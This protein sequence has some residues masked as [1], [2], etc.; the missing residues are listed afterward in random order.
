MTKSYFTTIVFLG[1]LLLSTLPGNAQDLSKSITKHLEI[2]KINASSYVHISTI[3]LDSGNTYPCNGFIYIDDKEAF[4]FDSPANE[5]AVQELIKLLTSNNIAIKGVVF[6]HF[7]RDCTEGI[8]IYQS[9]NI[10]TIAS[11]KTANM[12]QKNNSPLPDITFENDLRLNL[13]S[14]QII[15]QFVGEAH[16]S[17]NIISYF[18][19]ENILFGGCMIKSQGAQKGNLS[20]AN[21]NEWSNTVSNIKKTYP[22]VNIVIPGHGKWG[23][24]ELLDYTIKLFQNQS[25]N[26]K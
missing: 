11:T 2:H 7:H 14:K 26:E 25:D 20:D 18:P 6:N 1:L 19:A 21:V 16:T 8:E 5:E 12:M 17:D 3:T 9:L 22:N 15:N 23:D 10:P 24:V 4:I 13:K